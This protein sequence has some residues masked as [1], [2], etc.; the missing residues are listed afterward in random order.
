MNQV[1]Q[2]RYRWRAVRRNVLATGSL[3]AASLAG[4]IA[5]AAAQSTKPAGD[6]DILE[7]VIVTARSREESL[8]DA[9]LS[10]T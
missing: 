10:I 7:E 9:P 6:S 1:D 4:F 8:Y 2:A 3:A 5:P